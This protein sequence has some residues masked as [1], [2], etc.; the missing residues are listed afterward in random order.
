MENVIENNPI[1]NQGSE[2]MLM[3]SLKI[4]LMT[5]VAYILVSLLFYV[6]DIPRD[7]WIQYLSFL[8]LIG[9]IIIGT[10]Q[11]RDKH[12]GGFLSY[13]RCLGSG[14]LISL[15]VG[16][17][18]AVYVYLFFKFFDPGEIAKMVE[19]AEQGMAEKGLN[20]QQIDQAM[21]MSK[22]MM[23]PGIMAILNIFSM[24][25]WGTIFSLIISIFL[26][27]DDQSFDSTFNQ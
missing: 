2:S 3:H 6:L 16:L 5:G 9:G 13:G 10:T 1:E 24:V 27:K 23:T 18:M 25:F 19:M 11:F 4:G 12:S 22:K 17:V 15:T 20:E 26:K 7:S 14:V 21:A 8:I